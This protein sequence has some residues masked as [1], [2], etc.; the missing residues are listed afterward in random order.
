ML[1]VHVDDGKKDSRATQ[2]PH[3]TIIATPRSVR[4]QDS[5]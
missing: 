1:E 3:A 4:A 5:L 2:A